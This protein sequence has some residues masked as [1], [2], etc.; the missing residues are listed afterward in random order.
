MKELIRQLIIEASKKMGL[1]QEFTAFDLTYPKSPQFGDYASNIA[2][3][4]APLLKKAPREI[5]ARLTAVLDLDQQYFKKIEIAGPGFINFFLKDEL[6]TEKVKDI[7]ILKQNFGGNALGTGKKIQVEFISANPTGPLQMGNGRGG[8]TGDCLANV[9]KKS[10]YKVW[11]EYYLNDR[12]N[13]M[14][15]LAESVLRRFLE[16]QGINLGFPEELYQGEYVKAWAKEIKIK[17]FD[18]TKISQTPKIKAEIHAW[19][20]Q[21]ALGGVKRSAEEIAQIKYDRW[22]SEKSLYA[23]KLR[24]EV[25]QRLSDRQLIYEKEGAWWFKSSQY[26]D[27]KDRPIIKSNGDPTYFFSDILYLV[28]RLEERKFDKVLM[29]WGCD[30]HGDVQRVKAAAEV[31]GHKGQ[32]DII[33]YQLVSLKFKG[34]E[35]RMSKR[36]GNFITLDDLIHEVGL[37]AARFFFL[38]NSF[39]RAMEFDMALA[40]ER[41]QKNPVYYVQY[42]H[43]RIC[44]ILE[45]VGKVRIKIDE[46]ELQ[47]PA[48]FSLCKKLLQYPDLI[49]EVAEHY[50]VHFLPFYALDLAR[51]F[52]NFYDHCRVLDE[53]R[54]NASRVALIKATQIVLAD[55]LGLMGVHAPEKM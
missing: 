33:L 14:D 34:K 28:N 53:G 25:W 17:N 47:S 24:E 20:L 7:L 37:D 30:H 43:A 15:I 18:A 44:S 38:M 51:E 19:T 35:V 55:V 49:K 50:S 40:K 9:F 12:G 22:F 54:V 36:K 31:L 26:G 39:D 1:G 2:L 21:R 52:H 8:F 5:A 42:A 23:G 48:E 41:S 46:L 3:Q 10:G 4:L 29:I 13:Q 32:L 11:R 27:D 16:L 45:K 6:V